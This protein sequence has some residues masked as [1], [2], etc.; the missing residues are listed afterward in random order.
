MANAPKLNIDFYGPE[1]IADPVTAY[2]KMLKAGPVVWL[3]PQKM[4]AICGHDALTQ[5][6]RDH[7][8]FVSSE[9]VSVNEGFNAFLK[10]STL[11]SDPP[12]HH[13]RRKIT[14]A[15]LTPKALQ[16]VRERVQAE[17]RTLAERMVA[18]GKFDAAAE[19]APH[20]PLS[21]VRDLVGLGAF[22]SA[23]MLD[24]GAATFEMMGDPR[25]RWE[26]AQERLGALRAF[27]DDTQTLANLSPDGWAAAANRAGLAAGRTSG[28]SIKLMRDYIAPSLDTT[29]SAIGYGIHLFA[30]NPDQWDKLR[31]DRSLIKN[32]IEEIVRL[33]SPIRAFSR[34]V[35]HNATVAGVNL[36]EG[37]RILVV[38]GAANRDPAAFQAPDSFDITRTTKGHTG[39]GHGVHACL[40]L[41]LARLEMTCLFEELADRITRFVPA[42]PVETAQNATIY[43]FKSVPVEVQMV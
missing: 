13:A 37:E 4:H 20:L 35:K 41:H 22:G 6:L 27:L 15:P 18:Q 36:S 26:S 39:F 33:N 1:V 29:I 32:A 21:V 43:A 3:E 12:E 11:N 31:A 17:A 2:H 10:G 42:G 25:E 23:H 40:G 34:K 16:T 5:V 19:L 7:A 24:W 9:G 28:D 38:Y 30:Q 8:T 14:F